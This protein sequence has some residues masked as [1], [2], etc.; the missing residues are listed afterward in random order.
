MRPPSHT[1]TV[2]TPES[3]CPVTLKN[4][5]LQ[6]HE[7]PVSS[8]IPKV[9]LDSVSQAQALTLTST[10]QHLVPSGSS[11]PSGTQA[12]NGSLLARLPFVEQSSSAESLRV[13]TLASK[14]AACNLSTSILKTGKTCPEGTND[15]VHRTCNVTL[16]RSFFECDEI[17]V[18]SQISKNEE[19]EET[20]Y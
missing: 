16:K 15:Q 19:K 14:P 13:P 4:S 2:H 10:K 18:S 6:S 1:Q 8:Q 3:S 20:Q 7:V 5:S 11:C 12:S 9:E 17:P